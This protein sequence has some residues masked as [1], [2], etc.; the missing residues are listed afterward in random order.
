MNG[1]I[2]KCLDELD[3]ATPRLDYVRGMLETLLLIQDKPQATPTNATAAQ[4][5]MHVADEG[6]ILDSKARALIGKMPPIEYA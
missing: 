5:A 6:D 2:K 4:T 3:S 1:I